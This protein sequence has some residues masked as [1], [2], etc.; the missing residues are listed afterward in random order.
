MKMKNFI[1]IIF[2]VFLASTAS[3]DEQDDLRKCI[4][5]AKR[6]ADISLGRSNY[7]Y[8]GG[9]FSSDF[10]WNGTPPALC[11]VSSEVDKLV[12][13]GKTYIIDG[14]AGTQAR[15]LYSQKEIELK[16]ITSQMAVMEE[17]Y[18]K[19]L[20]AMKTRLK[21]PKPDLEK[22]KSSFD[23]Q[24]N[25]I[26]LRILGTNNQLEMAYSSDAVL[27][28]MREEI[29]NLEAKNKEIFGTLRHVQ[30]E[31][32]A[33]T[34]AD[35][36]K[37]KEEIITLKKSLASSEKS[38]KGK[39]KENEKL[40][41]QREQ[42]RLKNLELAAE[43]ET[44]KIPVQPLI[45]EIISEIGNEKF[46]AAHTGISSLRKLPT[47]TPE[48]NK[49]F[50]KAALSVVRPIPSS[51]VSRNLMA[52]KFL[53]RLDPENLKYV[54]KINSYEQKISDANEKKKID[55]IV[56]I[57]SVSDDLAK[58]RSKMA[59]AALELI[60]VGK[61]TRSQIKYYGG[62]VKSGERSGQ[63]FMDCGKQRVWFNPKSP[64]TAYADRAIS[65]NKASE[66]CKNAIKR[67]ALTQ[68][69]FHYFDTSYTVHNPVKSVT[70]VQG[71]DVKNAFGA[72]MKY[73]AYCLIQ[74][75]GNLDLSLMNK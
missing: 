4:S 34:P 68:P 49:I 16:N 72:K 56:G 46:D 12:V 32:K 14:F 18:S 65:E 57:I 70:Y 37:L 42:L 13:S 52:Y 69:D 23:T 30:A 50:I 7:K 63:Y 67:Q 48:V 66:M 71:F 59:K 41:T 19:F 45:D 6:Y 15:A 60:K 73:R 58:H 36:Q 43:L 75:S 1:T 9:W 47:Y 51:E 35:V 33:S 10:T 62:W 8:D 21:N 64:N 31:Q 38:T 11:Q 61:C 40:T 3:A 24:A 39:V 53:L 29:I 55:D 20:N 22:I 17:R 28:K 26:K 27:K 5:A 54:G 74:P 25:D 2:L 44:F